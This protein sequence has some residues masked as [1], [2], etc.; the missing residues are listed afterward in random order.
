MVVQD[1]D[2]LSLIINNI[3]KPLRTNYIWILDLKMLDFTLSN[4]QVLEENTC[5]TLVL[6]IN[7]AIIHVP[8]YWH[9]LIADIETLQLDVVPV[10]LLS[11]NTYHAFV[12]GQNM[13][14]PEYHEIKVIDWIPEYVNIYPSFNRSSMLCH[15]LG[16]GQNCCL[17]F[18]DSYS[19]FLK[20]AY[21]EDLV[22]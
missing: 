5:S 12:Y 14:K 7:G 18:T 1:S 16:N 6:S 13:I 17:T 19:R 22:G 4:I 9:L 15:D 21:V 20:N 2:G 10:S 11:N 8:A 3:N